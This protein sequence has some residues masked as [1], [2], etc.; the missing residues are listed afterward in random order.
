MVY[1]FKIYFNSINPITAIH[2][3]TSLIEK[4]KIIKRFI[5]INKIKYNELSLLEVR[6]LTES[7]FFEENI[8]KE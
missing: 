7:E 5:R 3:A 8:W 4:K 1:K 2:A 6:K